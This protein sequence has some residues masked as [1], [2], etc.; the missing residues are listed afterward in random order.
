VTIPQCVYDENRNPPA[1]PRVLSRMK[2]TK[3]FGSFKFFTMFANAGFLTARSPTLK[4]LR[5]A[6]LLTIKRRDIG[7]FCRKIGEF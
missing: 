4:A 7:D 5:L 1:S 6:A 3:S 2:A